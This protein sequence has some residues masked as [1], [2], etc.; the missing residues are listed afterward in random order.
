MSIIHVNQIRLHVL[1]LFGA[2]IDVSDQNNAPAAQRDD[3]LL[4]RSLAAYAVHFLSG[5]SPETSASSVM[6]GGNDNGLDAI[7]FDEANRRLYLVQSKWIKSGIGEPEN[8]DVKK[9]VAGIHDLFNMQ[10]DRFNWKVCARWVG[11]FQET[12]KLLCGLAIHVRS[13]DPAG[14]GY[15]RCAS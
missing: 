12:N 7:Y 4:T 9:F 5:A 3:F 11:F 6:D 8:G 14:Q 15:P 13:I 10:F 1:K 2:L